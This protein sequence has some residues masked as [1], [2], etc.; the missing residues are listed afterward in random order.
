MNDRAHVT[1][2]QSVFRHRAFNATP[3]SSAI[4]SV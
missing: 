2:G 3:S 1:G 4:M